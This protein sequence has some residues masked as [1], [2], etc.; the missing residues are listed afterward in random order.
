MRHALGSVWVIVLVFATACEAMDSVNSPAKEKTLTAIEA[1]IGRSGLP[2]PDTWKREYLDAIRPAIGREANAPCLEA[3]AKGFEAYWQGLKKSDD[4]PLFE[5]QLAQI[6]WY[7]EYLVTTGLPNA[8]QKQ[9]VKGQYKA[10]WNDAAN[11][12][13]TQFLF[14]DPNV[15]RKATEDDL[16]NCYR[17][18]DT[19]LLPIFLRPLTEARLDQLKQRWQDLRYSRVDLWRQIGNSDKNSQQSAPLSQHPHYLLTQRSLAQLL[20]Q[21]WA[22]AASPPDY[23]R[24]AAANLVA[25][26]EFQSRQ[27]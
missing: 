26:H 6:R 20:S 23:Y 14:L 9:K 12:L 17:K 27:Q 22:V 7:T 18:I 10:L 3:L 8:E 5:F 19:P 4:R 1:T 13:T 11:G 25:V 16:A 15:V 21:V 2:W 24:A